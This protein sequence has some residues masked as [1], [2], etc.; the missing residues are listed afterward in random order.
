MGGSTTNAYACAGSGGNL[1]RHADLIANQAAEN[2]AENAFPRLSH[3][4]LLRSL[5]A[6]FGLVASSGCLSSSLPPS[7]AS[8]RSAT[9]FSS[10]G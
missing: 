5:L 6:P 1:G 9:F 3:V 4:F 2:A 8:G 10:G 7:F